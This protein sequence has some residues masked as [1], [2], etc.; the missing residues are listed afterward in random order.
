MTLAFVTASCS[1][2]MGTSQGI[3]PSYGC[4]RSSTRRWGPL[5]TES[6]RS[7]PSTQ[8]PSPPLHG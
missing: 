5:L 3:V 4:G 8:E 2:R 6:Q 7:P 1:M